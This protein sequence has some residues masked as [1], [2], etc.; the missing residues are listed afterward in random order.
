LERGKR[1]GEGDREK[2]IQFA[3]FESNAKPVHFFTNHP[4]ASGLVVKK[5]R[6]SFATFSHTFDR[7]TLSGH[8]PRYAA[9][10]CGFSLSAADLSSSR[11]RPVSST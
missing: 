6:R 3:Q 7:V 1:G 2:R 11:M 4:F 10:T 9:L 8:P 5:S